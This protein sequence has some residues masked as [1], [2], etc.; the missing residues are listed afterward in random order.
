MRGQVIA[1]VMLGAGLLSGA[2]VACTRRAAPGTTAP[3]T[4][5]AATGHPGV[6]RPVDAGATGFD[7][8]DMALA[9]LAADDLQLRAARYVNPSVVRLDL[10]RHGRRFA[11]KWKA[12]GPGGSEVQEGHDGNNAPRCEVAAFL[13]ARALA[14][15]GGAPQ[16]LVPPMVV[17]AL[18]RDVP[19]ARACRGVPRLVGADTPATFPEINDHLV[20]GALALWIEDAREPQHLH[21]DLWRRE[22]FERDPA[23]RRSVSDLFLFLYVIAHGDA[24]Y[25]SNFLLAGSEGGQIYSIDNGRAFD[26]IPYYVGEGEADWQP[27]AAL[28]PGRLIA[29]RFAAQTVQALAQLTP[30]WLAQQLSL[31][32][33]VDLRSGR[34]AYAPQREAA[35]MAV[36]GRPLAG[37]AGLLRRSRQTYTG[38]LAAGGP[39]WLL[40]GIGGAGIAQTADRAAQLV[41]YLRRPGAPLF[42]D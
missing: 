27:M 6:P 31:C 7:A 12:M 38:V 4:A 2:Q 9:D 40:L 32:A 22:R 21:G 36:V 11:A 35:L 24:N 1:I 41:D 25:G 19:C 34:A 39:P 23:Y 42:S 14:A 29:P 26:G 28:S 10:E 18:H 30:A 3:A 17:R 16:V 8:L 33:A 15:A 37:V 5:G 20:L 13:L